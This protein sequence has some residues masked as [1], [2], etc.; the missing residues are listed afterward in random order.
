VQGKSARSARGGHHSQR[1]NRVPGNAKRN[2][3][4]DDDW[5]WP[6]IIVLWFG[7]WTVTRGLARTSAGAR[8][9]SVHN[10]RLRTAT[11]TTST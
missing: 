5:N 9:K 7:G 4:H 8:E 11:T 6:A 1:P 10:L 3:R 2:A